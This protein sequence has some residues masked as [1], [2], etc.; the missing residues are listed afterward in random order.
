M[1]KRIDAGHLRTAVVEIPPGVVREGGRRR[2]PWESQ[3][4]RRHEPDPERCPDPLDQQHQGHICS[5]GQAVSQQQLRDWQRL[6][7]HEPGEDKRFAEYERCED[8]RPSPRR[9]LRAQP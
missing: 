6:D 3:D 9:A 4:Q 7:L 8:R 2:K 1:E 5:E